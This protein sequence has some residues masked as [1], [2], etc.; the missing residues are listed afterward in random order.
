MDEAS[1][2]VKK[3]V[4]KLRPNAERER[5]A[6]EKRQQTEGES[7]ST[8][9]ITHTNPQGEKARETEGATGVNPVKE[10]NPATNPHGKSSGCN[11]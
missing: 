2:G 9:P 1:Q 5:I 10:T 6:A 3:A 11:S 4:Y 7:E 8:P